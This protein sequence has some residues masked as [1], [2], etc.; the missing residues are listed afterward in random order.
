VELS[1]RGH[2]ALAHRV[3]WLYMTG[4]W[5]AGDIDH[6][7]NNRSDNRFSNL[8]PA[9]RSL[10]IAN[11]TKKKSNS[12]GF[13]GVSFSKANR[14]WFA[15]ITVNYRQQSLGY[16][17]TPQEAHA[18]YVHAAREAFGEFANAGVVRG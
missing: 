6:I 18:A 10:N 1:L 3:A 4:E 11:S 5:P 17:N 9:T 8:R 13:K 7:N 16:F 14:K 2:R 15:K 12:S